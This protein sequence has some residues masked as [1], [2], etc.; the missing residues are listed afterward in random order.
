[1]FFFG[2][3]SMAADEIQI[4]AYIPEVTQK[5]DTGEELDISEVAASGYTLIYFYPKAD[6]PG[7]TKQ[8]CSLRDAYEEL[9]N[10]G[11]EV[12]GVSADTVKEQADFKAKFDLPF[13]LL[14]DKDKKVIKALGVP[15]KKKDFASR[16]AYLFK[17]GILM[18]RD[19]HASTS[20]QAADVLAVVKQ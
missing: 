2:L 13:T 4:G 17:D 12:I 6:T 14:A 11:V 7:C 3:F 19:L 8:A 9:G 16:Q 15:L 18:W 1:M 5:T 10:A 20:K